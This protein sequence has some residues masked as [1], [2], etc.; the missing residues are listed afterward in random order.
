M[1]HDSHCRRVQFLFEDFLF[2]SL[3]L[4]GGVLHHRLSWALTPQQFSCLSFLS[5]GSLGRHR[6]KGPPGFVLLF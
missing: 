3:K 4:G 2:V 1:P 6:V 5:A